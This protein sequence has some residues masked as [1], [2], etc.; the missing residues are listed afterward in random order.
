[1][2]VYCLGRAWRYSG[3]SFSGGS[4]STLVILVMVLDLF[5]KGNVDRAFR[6]IR[7]GCNDAAAQL[8]CSLKPTA[9]MRVVAEFPF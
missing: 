3:D 5:V 7:A 4:L 2:V 8:R 1:M 9:I 6:R